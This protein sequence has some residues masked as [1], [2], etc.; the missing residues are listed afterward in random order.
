[1]EKTYDTLETYINLAKKTI[2][3]FA[4]KMYPSLVKEM[5]NNDEVISEIAEAIMIADW[6]WDE[7][8]VG[9]STGMKKTIYSYR[10]QCAI[11]AIKTYATKQYKNNKKYQDQID[12]YLS[13][14]NSDQV[15]YSDPT[16]KEI[17][18]KEYYTN[19]KHDMSQLLD[20]S[21]ITDKQRDI[22][23]QY[24]YDNKTLAEIGRTYGVTREAIRQNLNKSL[25]TI[26]EHAK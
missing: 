21:P 12:K 19:L 24:Y 1:M 26:R 16:Q 13:T 11:W 14:Y 18:E 20:M 10:N 7:N 3:K 25:N 22:I 6:K 2:S 23:K 17:E 4:G 15:I 5:L 8:R 9:K